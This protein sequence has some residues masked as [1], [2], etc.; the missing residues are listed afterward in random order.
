MVR[1]KTIE[2][3]PGKRIRRSEEQLIADLE[4]K[5]QRLKTRVAARAVKKDPSLRHTTNAVR[6][7][8]LALSS[9]SSAVQRQALSEA[10]S[11]LVT[12][13]QLE[14]IKIPQKRRPK[15]KLALTLEADQ[16][17]PSAAASENR[18]SASS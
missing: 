11:A 12:Y 13:L 17:R 14:G 18:Y 1:T 5:I 9:V 4:S 15:R 16:V 7:I 8:D 10:R 6:S 2:P 3:A